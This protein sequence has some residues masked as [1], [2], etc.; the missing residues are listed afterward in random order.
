MLGPGRALEVLVDNRP[1]D[2]EEGLRLG[3]FNRVVADDVLRDEAL[4]WAASIAAGPRNAYRFMKENV[5]DAQQLSLRD[6]LP[7]EADR[8]RASGQTEEHRQAVKRW[9]EEARARTR[10]G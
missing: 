8:M 2:A 5:R 10:G 6:A 9:L 4:S 3:V 1:I 7:L